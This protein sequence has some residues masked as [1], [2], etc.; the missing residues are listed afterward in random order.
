MI[1]FPLNLLSPFFLEKFGRRP[2]ILVAMFG[3]ILLP[4]LA[5]VAKI[6]AEKAGPSQW[7]MVLGIMIVFGRTLI[8]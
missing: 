6:W 5:F 8:A 7:T 4:L 1:N 3:Y 2:L